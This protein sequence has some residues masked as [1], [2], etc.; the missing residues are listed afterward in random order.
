MSV[1]DELQVVFSF[2]CVYVNYTFMCIYHFIL[3]YIHIYISSLEK[4]LLNYFAQLKNLVCLSYRVVRILY[5]FCSQSPLSEMFGK[6]FL[7]VCA[8]PFHFLNSPF[9]TAEII[10]F[11]EVQHINFYLV[12]PHLRNPPPT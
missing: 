4:C 10:I 11:D 12:V 1:N 5:K 3:F 7:P 2:R 6:Y 8:G 9:Q